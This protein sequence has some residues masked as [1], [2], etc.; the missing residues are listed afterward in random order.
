MGKLDEL[1]STLSLLVKRQHYLDRWM[2][3][4]FLLSILHNQYNLHHINKY[5]VTR[6]I[7][8]IGLKDIYIFHHRE[9]FLFGSK[10]QNPRRTFFI[11]FTAKTECPKKLSKEEFIKCFNEFRILRTDQITTPTNNKRKA[12]S[13]D[14]NPR[15]SN[16]VTSPEEEKIAKEMNDAVKQQ[17]GN[18]FT[19]STVKNLFGCQD[20][21]KVHDCLSRRIDTFDDIIANKLPIWKLINKCNKKIELSP[22]QTMKTIQRI[23][24][25]K[26]AYLAVLTL[27][28]SGT[29]NFKQCCEQAIKK[30]HEFG[31]KMI[32]SPKVLMKLNRYF[33]DKE[34]LPHP[35]L[36]IEL[37]RK[38]CGVEN[39]AW[40]ESME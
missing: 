24:Y 7:N 36:A 35:N 3:V 33:R 31:F 1:R 26:Q 4:D 20:N 34:T 6:Y 22:S 16:N 28:S 21:E 40:Q 38:P 11:I 29:F 2:A 39:V 9:D 23:L 17:I 19:S 13:E 14:I 5:Y 12:S 32:K 27:Q 30:C 8:N 15:S 25:L 37:G 10:S 18:Y